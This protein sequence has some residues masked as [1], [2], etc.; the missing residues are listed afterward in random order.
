MSE[1]IFETLVDCLVDSCKILFRHSK[2][3]LG[4]NTL[5]FD[6]LFKEIEICNKSKEFPKLDN[7]SSSEYIKTY[8][9]KTPIG[10]KLSAFKEHS[11]EISC[12]LNVDESDLRFSRDKNKIYIKVI[13]K[14]PTCVYDAIKHKRND[15]K[16]PIGYSLET[17]KLVLWDFTASTNAHCYI[18]GSS[19]GGKSVMLR[20]ILSHLVNSKSKRDVE[21]SIINTKRVDLKDFKNAKHTVNYMT[22]IDGVEDFL[23]NEVD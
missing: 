9:F 8:T 16:I 13:L 21:F 14:K 4:L 18:A 6:K 10:I 3:T 23:E 11:E 1:N 20:V 22:G 17:T 5:D 19:G 7:T 15:F 2:N 12:F